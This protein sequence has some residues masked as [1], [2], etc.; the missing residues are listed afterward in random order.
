MLMFCVVE[1]IVRL[2]QHYVG[3]NIVVVCDV[4]YNLLILYRDDR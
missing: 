4:V 1:I 2:W 3:A